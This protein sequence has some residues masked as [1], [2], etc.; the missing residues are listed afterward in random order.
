MILSVP[1]LIKDGPPPTEMQVKMQQQSRTI[2]PFCTN[3]VSNALYAKYY[4][5]VDAFQIVLLHDSG[6]GFQKVEDCLAGEF[7]C[8]QL[9]Q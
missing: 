8:D 1:K 7:S 3:S 2:I 9:V 5:S 4:G 6:P